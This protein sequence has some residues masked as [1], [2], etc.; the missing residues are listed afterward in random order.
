MASP[1]PLF[2]LE[3][4]HAPLGAE[5]LAAVGRVI[6]TNRFI[7]GPEI[8]ALEAEIAAVCGVAHAIGCSSGSD[9]LLLALV[10]LGVGPGDAV[11][12][13]PHTFFATA[14]AIARTGARPVF[15]DVDPASQNLDP[16]AVGRW[17]AENTD[18]RGRTRDGL[19]VRVVVPVHLY[20]QC[21]DVDA[22]AEVVA[23]RGIRILEDAAQA[24]GASI[25]DR[26]AGSLGALAAFS[27][28]PSK[29]LGAAGD[30]GIVTTDDAALAERVRSLRVHGGPPGTRFVHEE[31]GWNARIDSIQAAFLRVKVPHLETWT[32]GRIENAE[33][34][35]ESLADLV[36]RGVTTPS[37]RAATRHV[38][39]LYALRVS[40]LPDLGPGRRD[41]I[42]AA[43]A[44][45]GIET[46]VYY[47]RPLHLQPCFAHL[48]QGEGSLPEA[49]RAALETL[50]IPVFPELGEER[51][52][53]VA[54]AV[55]RAVERVD[56]APARSTEA[57]G[58]S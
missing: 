36:A 34:Y 55:R 6:E 45:D 35:D 57:R 52:G 37:R 3:A 49:E 13:S 58:A 32:A 19:T 46:G 31:L 44:E 18:A 26:P 22:L 27:F 43:L 42:A 9:A 39:H 29:N 56:A 7:G 2:D 17:L 28:Y 47:P 1:I 53:R 25:G 16:E 24:I 15:C 11:I 4:Q 54:D 8:D 33:F 50:S 40:D 10:A 21:A 20:G 23:S 5:L 12:T 38:Y 51:R 14:G 48:G 30:A 41:R